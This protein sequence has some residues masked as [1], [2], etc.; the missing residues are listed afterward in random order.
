MK[1]FE[2]KKKLCNTNNDAEVCSSSE[3]FQGSSR[4]I[5]SIGDVHGSYTG[6]LENLYYAKIIKSIDECEW[7][8]QIADSIDS[9]YNSTLLVQV[10][11]I[12]DRGEGATEAQNCLKKLQFTANE[13]NSK[14]I[15]LLGS[16][17]TI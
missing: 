15:R 8:P 2:N 16:N 13:Y 12:V 10:G 1:Q 3:T 7:K 11:D 6:L 9:Y 14:V 17:N 4:R 5:V